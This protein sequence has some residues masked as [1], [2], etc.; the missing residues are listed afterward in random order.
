MH[1]SYISN[2]RYVTATLL[3][4]FC[5][6]LGWL[7]SYEQA[8]RPSTNEPLLDPF[9]MRSVRERVVSTHS[10]ALNVTT[11]VNVSFRICR[12]RRQCPCREPP[13]SPWQ[14]GFIL[15][16][17]AN[18]AGPTIWWTHSNLVSQITGPLPPINAGGLSNSRWHRISLNQG[19][20]SVQQWRRRSRSKKMNYYVE[21]VD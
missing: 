18:A 16:V 11:I 15:S 10:L 1:I 3:R 14:L 20:H 13:A 7:G 19:R 21:D 8:I 12:R 2:A 17:F 5:S 6:F 4:W 9:K